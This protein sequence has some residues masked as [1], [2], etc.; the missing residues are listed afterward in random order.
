MVPGEPRIAGSHLDE[1]HIVL[2]VLVA[3]IDE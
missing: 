1:E 3:Q 2:L